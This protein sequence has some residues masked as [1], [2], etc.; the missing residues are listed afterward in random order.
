MTFNKINTFNLKPDKQR[1]IVTLIEYN[2]FAGVDTITA[3]VTPYYTNSFCEAKG[4]LIKFSC[5]L[6]L[7]LDVAKQAIKE[8]EKE[9]ENEDLQN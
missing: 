8:F 6:N 2:N 9:I 7:T 5:S 4:K 3:M 1:Y